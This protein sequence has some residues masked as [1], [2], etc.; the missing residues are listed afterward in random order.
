MRY[1]IP[2]AARFRL[3]QILAKRDD[4]M[5]QSDVARLS[6]VSLNTVNGIFNNRTTR[7]DLATLDAIAGVLGIQPGDLI[8]RDVP[9]KSRKRV[10]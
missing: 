3:D 1:L 10:A 2:V 7:V 8:V 4:G 6:G 5:R 9:P